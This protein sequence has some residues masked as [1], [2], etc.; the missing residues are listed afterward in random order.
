MWYILLIGVGT[1]GWHVHHQW[2]GPTTIQEVDGGG[3]VVDVCGLEAAIEV[4]EQ[5]D[6]LTAIVGRSED[7][8]QSTANSAG[9]VIPNDNSVDQYCQKSVLVG[10]SV[11]LEEC[12][13]IVITYRGP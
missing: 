3:H 2:C 10:S 1:V 5:I 13:C 9:R 7:A 8:W 6:L 11:V 12:C 4:W